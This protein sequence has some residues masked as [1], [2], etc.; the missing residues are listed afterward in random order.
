VV[1][2]E[3]ERT[4][5]AVERHRDLLADR[6]NSREIELVEPGEDWSE[7]SYSAKADMSVL[8]PE[9]GDDSGRVMQAL[10]DARVGEKTLPALENAVERAT[11]MDVDLSEEMVEFVTQTPDGVTGVAFDTDGDQR[12]VVY[13]DTELTE[14]IESEGYAREV[15]R[16]VQEMRK[17]LDLEIE[18]RVRLELDVADERVADLVAE[19][20][21]LVKEEVRADE[22]GDVEDGYRK[23]WEVEGVEMTIAVAPLAEAEA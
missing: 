21:D 22:V 5:E 18:Q 10:N 11:G 20:M 1:T 3:D 9:F 2:A 23:E 19:R 6:L 17:D 14:D 16:R 7:L 8:G 12:G 4:V 15:V 13:V